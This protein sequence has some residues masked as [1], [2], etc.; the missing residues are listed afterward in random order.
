MKT[1]VGFVS[2]LLFCSLVGVSSGQD[3]AAKKAPTVVGVR[4]VEQHLQGGGTRYSATIGASRQVDLAFKVGG[5]VQELL[6]VQGSDGQSH[7]VQEGDQVTKGTILAR[8]RPDDFVVK[9]QQ[10]KAQVAEAQ[11]SAEQARAQMAEA[12]ATRDQARAQLAE[13]KASYEQAR[14]D[15]ARASQLFAVQSLTKPEHDAAEAKFLTMQAKVSAAQAQGSLAQASADKA[16]AQLQIIQARIQGAQAQLAEAE[17]ALRDSALKAPLDAVVLKRPIEVGTLVAPNSVGFVLADTATVEAVFGVPDLTV[18]RLRLGQELVLHSE[19]V[20][21]LEWRGRITR[22]APA[23]D[24]K[25]RVFEV[26]VTVPNPRQQLKVGSIASL[27]VADER[28]TS[29]IAVVPLSAIVRPKDQPAGYAVFV[30]DDHAGKTVARSRSVQLGETFGN[31]VAVREGLKLGERVIT[32]GAA[33]VVD[34]DPVRIAP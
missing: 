28:S 34:G 20:P 29:P 32:T 33:Q 2:V 14:L 26:E 30:V 8:L 13:A 22:I 15:W 1:Q 16:R 31:L 3:E 19:A 10:A 21:G 6:Q 12:Q 24:T 4:V 17:L 5:Y 25:S 7:A 11:A 23:A 18:Q 9:Q 27:Q